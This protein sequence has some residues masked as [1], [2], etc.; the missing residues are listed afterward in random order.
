[1]IE[2]VDALVDLIFDKCSRNP[3]AYAIRTE[4]ASTYLRQD[5]K[6]RFGFLKD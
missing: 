3:A 5:N 6:T 4:P 2:D 1:V